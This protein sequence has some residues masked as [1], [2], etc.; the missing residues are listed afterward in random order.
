MGH[1]EQRQAGGSKRSLPEGDFLAAGATPSER[2]AGQAADGRRCGGADGEGEDE[3]EAYMRQVN[4]EAEAAKR[5]RKGKEK[6]HKSMAEL[7]EEGL[8]RPLGEGS[9]GYALL[10]KMGYL[11][12]GPAPL[13][14]R[15]KAGRAGLGVEEGARRTRAAREARRTEE[16]VAAVEAAETRQADFRGTQASVYASRRIEAQL[17]AAQ[18]ACETLDRRKTDLQSSCL[19][20]VE[21]AREAEDEGGDLEAHAEGA[22]PGENTA[23]PEAAEDEC[24]NAEQHSVPGWAAMEPPMR[25]AAA[26][27]YL[28]GAHLYCLFCGH[29]Y[30][31]EAEMREECPGPEEEAH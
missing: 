23:S 22:E 20:P 18:Q 9:R 31:S 7:R 17:R 2:L 6:P 14:V 15:M 5:P 16:A 12:G 26:L 29:E 30:A 27:E 24:S 10:A 4:A 8:C 28:R 25:L 13:E 21:E 19:W 1:R 3:L 11:G